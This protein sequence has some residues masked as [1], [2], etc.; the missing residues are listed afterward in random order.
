MSLMV[1]PTLGKPF[2]NVEFTSPIS[3]FPLLLVLYHSCN[4]SIRRSLLNH[5]I[6]NRIAGAKK[7]IA[8]AITIRLSHLVADFLFPGVLGFNL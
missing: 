4:P 8:S 6:L 7:T 2:K 5:P 3:R 1:N